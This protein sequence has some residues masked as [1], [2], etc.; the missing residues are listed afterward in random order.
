MKILGL[1]QRQEP[2]SASSARDRLQTL[3][4][5]ERRMRGQPEFLPRM[6]QDLLDVVKR[7]V[8]INMDQVRVQLERSDRES[9][10][11]I[12]VTFAEQADHKPSLR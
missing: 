2:A 11:E 5:H 10:L 3:L 9:I 7:Y 8:S 6:Q 4:A 1:F 12:N